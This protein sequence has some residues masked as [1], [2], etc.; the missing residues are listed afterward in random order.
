MK[1]NY[2]NYCALFFSALANP[3]RIKILQELALSPMTVN[4]IVQKVGAERTLVSHNLALLTQAQLVNHVKAGKTRV[5]SANQ[6]VVPYVFFV[7]DR[8]VCSRCSLRSTCKTLKERGALRDL[9]LQPAGGAMK[10]PC[11]CSE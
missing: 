3:V 8:I 1:R 11:A 10:R 6:Y 4:E 2:G 5:Y 9:P 7:I